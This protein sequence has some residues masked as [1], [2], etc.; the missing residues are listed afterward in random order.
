M[1]L[2]LL[3]YEQH[4]G[5]GL[6]GLASWLPVGRG[7]GGTPGGNN[8]LEM[9]LILFIR[10]IPISYLRVSTPVYSHSGVSHLHLN[11]DW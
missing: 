1:I 11:Q 6:P 4:M 3:V 9:V 8:I 5:F 7:G 10:H 2:M